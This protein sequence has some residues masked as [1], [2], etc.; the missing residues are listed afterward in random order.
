MER[1]NGREERA[2]GTAEWWQD[3]EGE[4]EKKKNWHRND[5]GGVEE[6]KEEYIKK[7]NT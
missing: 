4:K 5:D 2:E 1:R 3:Q 6:V 7:R